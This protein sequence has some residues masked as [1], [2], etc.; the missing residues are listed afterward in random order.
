MYILT[1]MNGLKLPNHLVAT[2]VNWFSPLS[3][4]ICKVKYIIMLLIHLICK[5]RFSSFRF[6]KR[7]SSK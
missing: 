6:T 1:H 5:I 3:Y 4:E 7:G 2:D